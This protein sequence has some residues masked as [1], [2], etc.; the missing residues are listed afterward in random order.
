LLIGL[1]NELIMTVH[2]KINT[3]DCWKRG[4]QIVGDSYTAQHMTWRTIYLE[5]PILIY[6]CP[7]LTYNW[8]LLF[9]TCL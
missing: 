5:F 3:A 2:I 4:P 8:W 1:I 6:N 7:H 9:Q